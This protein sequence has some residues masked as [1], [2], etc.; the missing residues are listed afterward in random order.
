MTTINVKASKTYDIIIANDLLGQCGSII[1]S[2]A[3]R[4]SLKGRNAA[5]VMDDNVAELY[6]EKLSLSLKENGYEVFRFIFPNG[7]NSKNEDNY[8]KLLNFLAENK[9]TRSDIII[10]FGGGVTGDLAGFAAATYMRGISYIQFPTTLLAAVDSSIGGKT[11]INL[12]AGKNLAGAFYQPVLVL[13]DTALLSTLEPAVF[14][15]GCAEMIKHG[16]IADRELFFS[17][18]KAIKDNLEDTIARNVIIK[19]DIVIEDEFEQGNRKLLNFGHT[20]GHAIEL[21]SSFKTGHGNAV[22][23]GMVIVTRAAL[24]MGICKEETLS[25]LLRMLSLYNLPAATSYDAASLAEAC[26]GDK[27]RSGGS[28][29]MIF[30]RDIGNCFLKE[31]NVEQIN[32]IIKMGLDEKN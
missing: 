19:R 2:T 10:A 17:Y 5:I 29:T 16:M 13:C 26:L 30:P 28:I 11:A 4:N 8:F 25:E 23:A 3:E 12:A 32:D 24:R 22:A 15:D 18:K 6:G 7:E 31:I 21:L 27:K 14:A 20:V 1:R 9:F